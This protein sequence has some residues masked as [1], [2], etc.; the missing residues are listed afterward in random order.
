MLNPKTVRIPQTLVKREKNA[1]FY[2]YVKYH[3]IFISINGIG[4]K[5][6]YIIVKKCSNDVI[7]CK[8]F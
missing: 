2:S 6:S 8:H 4:D 3:L 1:I 5:R 7:V